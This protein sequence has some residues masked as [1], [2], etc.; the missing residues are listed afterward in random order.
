MAFDWS[1][2]LDL[3]KVWAAGALT[4]AVARSAVSRAYYAA[5]HHALSY[6]ETRLGHMRQGMADE[7]RWIRDK[8]EDSGRNNVADW[9][10][11]LRQ[12]RNKCDYQDE[13]RDLETCMLPDALD[14][15]EAVISSLIV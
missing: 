10:D 4:E 1:E 6:S 5:Y 2:Y 3:A 15:A 11:K 12:H 9:L 14:L 13:V 7:H 8:I